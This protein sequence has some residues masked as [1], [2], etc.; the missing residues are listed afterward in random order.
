LATKFEGTVM[1]QVQDLTKNFKDRTVLD[2]V[3]FQVEEGEI[4]GYL[5]PNG[6]GAEI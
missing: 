1:I 6:A 2:N 5:R 4:F 3:D